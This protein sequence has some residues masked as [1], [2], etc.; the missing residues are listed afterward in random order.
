MK[1]QLFLLL[2]LLSACSTFRQSADNIEYDSNG[3]VEQPKKKDGKCYAKAMIP[4]LYGNSTSSYPVYTGKGI[5]EGVEEKAIVLIPASTKWV[6]KTDSKNCHS[7]DP[8][9]CLVWCLVEVP[10]EVKTVLIVKDTAKIKDFEM[11]SF[12]KRVLAQ[13]G[14]VTELVEIVCEKEENVALF[15]QIST[16]LVARGYLKAVQEIKNDT[17][18]SALIQFQ[19]DKGLPVGNMNVLTMKALGVLNN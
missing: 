7:A 13:A 17:L 16:A 14:G 2:L 8:N 10:S 19:K 11:R 4:D 3:V 1:N 6:K 9:D 12:E 18:N 5:P 15:Q